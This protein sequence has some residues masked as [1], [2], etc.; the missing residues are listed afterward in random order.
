VG[1]E[2]TGPLVDVSVGDGVPDGVG[3]P[4]GVALGVLLGVGVDDVLL[5][6]GVAVLLC[7]GCGW[8]LSVGDGDVVPA[9]GAGGGRTSM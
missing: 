2:V 4:E 5:G 1:A 3:V 9:T 6:L 7:V 8:L